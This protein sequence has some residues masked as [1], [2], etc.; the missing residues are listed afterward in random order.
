M[1][2]IFTQ[3]KIV[4]L[5]ILL[6]YPLTQ[7]LSQNNCGDALER[8]ETLFDQG[9]IEE[10][11]ALLEACIRDG[12]S[13]EEKV[14]AQKLVILSYLFDN[15]M[16]DAEGKMVSFLRANPEYQLEPG[17]PSEFASLFSSY[18]TFPFLSLGIFTGGNISSATMLE[19]FGPYSPTTDEV[20]YSITHPEYQIGISFN[21]FL[22]NSF[23]LNLETVYAK[24]SFSYSNLQYGFIETYRKE[25]HSRLEFPVSFTFDFPGK[26]LKPYL[27]LGAS[28]GLILN[29]YGDYK[30]S[31]INS[32]DEMSGTVESLG[33][34]ISDRR[35][36]DVIA[37]MV[38]TGLKYKIPRGHLFLD[39]RYH[40]GLTELVKPETRWDPEIVF[41]FYQADED[42]QIDYLT[43]SFG[44]RYSF[45]KSKKL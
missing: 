19:Q 20:S 23:E 34:D 7:V 3:V 16:Y 6:Q 27:R 35:N 45:F 42:F 9:V 38:G 37:A 18:R 24:T 25:S 29:A 43:F 30:R 32:S 15:R 31:N 13:R 11:P 28:Y 21:I 8:A 12:F 17:D 41:P 26:K 5:F 36:P 44:F 33:I 1:K 14:R 2:T 22:S 10:I 40:Y 4:V 39:L